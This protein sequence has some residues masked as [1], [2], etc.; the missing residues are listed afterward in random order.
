MPGIAVHAASRVL[1]TEPSDRAGAQKARAPSTELRGTRRMACG[2]CSTAVTAPSGTAEP[3][4]ARRRT[5]A[6]RT[7]LEDAGRILPPVV[8]GD[9]SAESGC[10]A[11]LGLAEHPDRTTVFAA[12]DQMALGLLRA[13]NERGRRVPED[14]AV[15]GFDDL[16]ESGPFRPPGVDTGAETGRKAWPST[17]LDRC[18]A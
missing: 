4:A 10:R 18:R 1:D 2:T 6:C 12:N 14:V 13:S 17:V 8:R 16:P 5:A 3:Y 15:I 11:G 9:R 7:A